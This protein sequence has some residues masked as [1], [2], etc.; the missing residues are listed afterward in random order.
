MKSRQKLSAINA[1]NSS[2]L[3][4]HRQIKTPETRFENGFSELKIAKPAG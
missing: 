4:N 3:H 1:M 2:R